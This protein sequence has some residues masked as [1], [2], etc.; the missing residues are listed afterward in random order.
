[1]SLNRSK[2][3]LELG[4]R[5]VAQLDDDDDLLSSWMAHEIAARMQA[6][7]VASGEAK[8]LAED[9]C[10]AAIL[11]L[12]RHRNA[13]PAHQRPFSELEP[14]IRT[15][16]SLD[17]EG[18]GYRYF[19]H[20]LREAAAGNAEGKAKTWLEFAIGLDYT[21]RLLIKS[22]L[23]SAAELAASSAQA[24]VDLANRAGADEGVEPLVVRFALDSDNGGESETS[25]ENEVLK[26]RLA[27]IEA[28]LSVASE[29]AD[30][31]RGKLNAVDKDPA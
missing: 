10:A 3:V 11:E 19:P 6:V 18:S 7:E 25:K 16:A 14:V 20:A 24:W 21:A 26:E 13:L 22:A 28:F 9:A 27:R 12:W 2:A 15:I 29:M 8:R 31:L 5:L 30:D 23:R 1:V 4:K 17:V